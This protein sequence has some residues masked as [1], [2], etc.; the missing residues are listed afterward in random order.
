M[1]G[2]GRKFFIQGKEGHGHAKLARAE[3]RVSGGG[4]VFAEEGV[5]NLRQDASAIAGAGIGADASA[6]SQIDEAGQGALDDLARGPAGDVDDE[7]D[8]ARVALERRI[9]ER[10]ATSA[11]RGA[12]CM[13]LTLRQV[14]TLSTPAM[15]QSGRPRGRTLP[16]P[17]TKSDIHSSVDFE[18]SGQF[19]TTQRPERLD[20]SVAI[21][22][23]RPMARR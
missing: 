14:S 13:I 1:T 7:T 22:A 15:S 23:A 21:W 18:R 19:G 20:A 4:E 17:G 2:G 6:M 10:G 9:P 8:A 3:V 12:A 11:E 16:P 5:G